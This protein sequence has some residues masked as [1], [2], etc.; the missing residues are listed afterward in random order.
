[1][2][3]NKMTFG[4]KAT[5]FY[6]KK[7]KK[8][9]FCPA[10][11][12]KQNGKLRINK[13]GDIWVCDKCHYSLLDEEFIDNYVF[14]FCDEC[15]EF[16]NKQKNFDRFALNHKCLK[17]GCISPLT[18]D[19]LVGICRDCNKLLTNPD[20]TIC[21]ACKTNRIIKAQAFLSTTAGVLKELAEDFSYEEMN[22][23]SSIEKKCAYCGN[24]EETF[25]HEEDGTYYCSKCGHRTRT[26]DG[27]DDVVECP[28]CHRLRDRKA[29]YC[30]H[31]NDSTWQASTKEEFEEIDKILKG[32]L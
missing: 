16:L 17:C 28:Y 32:L 10:C 24:T 18:N 25:L 1:M 9:M 23:N 11:E 30:R 19:N 22:K 27:E 31:C 6:L 26:A 4:E 20:T 5:H 3:K 13:T 15:G 29:L 14:W 8:W 7:I 2:R 12:S 21:E